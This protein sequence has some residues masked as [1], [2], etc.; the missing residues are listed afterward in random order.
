VAL[1]SAGPACPSSSSAAL[2]TLATPSPRYGH[3][4][5]AL[6]SSPSV[7]SG[8]EEHHYLLL[9]G[10]DDGGSGATAATPGREKSRKYIPSY[11]DDVWMLHVMFSIDGGGQ[12]TLGSSA[13]RRVQARGGA[14]GGEG[15]GGGGEAPHAAARQGHSAFVHKGCLVVFGG[16]NG[17]SL[18]DLWT[19]CPPSSSPLP[20]SSPSPS[21][22]PPSTLSWAPSANRDSGW[23]GGSAPSDS[24]WR[25]QR[26]QDNTD[27]NQ[28]PRRA[29]APRPIARHFRLYVIYC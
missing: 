19:F 10:G 27:S 12:A 11:Y 8:N 29:A 2:T 6:S 21:Q 18:N 15:G 20:P 22:P 1:P 9:F 26:L 4:L 24:G 17:R 7:A 16:F 14:R 28:T 5:N 3:T 13:W 23:G 25:W